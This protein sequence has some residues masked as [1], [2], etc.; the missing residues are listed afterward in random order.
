MKKINESDLLN[1]VARLREKVVAEM[2]GGGAAQAQQNAAQSPSLMDRFRTSIGIPAGG[3]SPAGA[4][5]PAKP[6]GAA[7]PAG[8]TAPAAKP[9]AKPDPTTME[10][11]KKLIAAGAKIKADGIM[12]PATRAAQQQFPNVTTQPAAAQAVAADLNAG[13]KGPATVPAPAPAPEPAPAPAPAPVT[14]TG[15]ETARLAGRVP[16]PAPAPAPVTDTGDETARLA[17][18]VPAPAPAPAQPAGVAGATPQ[19]SLP[20]SDEKEFDPTWG[21]T[22]APADTRTGMEKFLPNFLGGKSAPEAANKNATWNNAQ[23]AAVSNAPAKAAAPAAGQA[24]APA[25]APAQ[26]IVK[27]LVD[28][29]GNPVLSGS[30]ATYGNRKNNPDNIG[31]STTFQNDELNRIISLVRHR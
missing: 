12:G 26:N 17:G 23:Q 30:P 8:A 9:V 25:A 22:K 1:R 28:R 31:E 7:A 11:Q 27:G 2:G 20:D 3:T 13:E 10:L 14:D 15:D 6:G 5:A 21:G 4:A 18:R 29:N 16:A 24:A 19:T